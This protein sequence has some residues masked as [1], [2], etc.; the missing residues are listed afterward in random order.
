MRQYTIAIV[1]GS[2][3]QD[4]FNRAVAQAVARLAPADFTCEEVSIAALP[5]YNQDADGHEEEAV[6]QFRQEIAASDAVLFATPEYNRSIPGVLK[7][8]LDQGS[9]PW[10]KSVW[11]G[12]PAAVI[13][14]SPGGMGTALAQQHLK[15]VLSFLNMPTLCQPE[16]YLQFKEGLL[17]KNGNI[18]EASKGFLQGFVD[19]FAAW[20][21]RNLA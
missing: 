12:K 16:V 11:A 7:N 1:V 19:T 14:V 5:L 8:A 21:R 4:S 9:R 17:D 18:G 2:L 20:V 6:R 10:G 3:R 15:S 13:G